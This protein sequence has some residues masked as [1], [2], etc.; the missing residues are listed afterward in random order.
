MM[1]RYQFSEVFTQAERREYN[2]HKR[3]RFSVIVQVVKIEL[4][5]REK[6]LTNMG[7]SGAMSSSV[8]LLPIP[9][10]EAYPKLPDSLLV[11]LERELTT[12][13]IS[14]RP[15][16]LVSGNRMVGHLFSSAS[17]FPMDHQFPPISPQRR[18]CQNSAFIPKSSSDGV[19][20]PLTQS[21]RSGVQSAPLINYPKEKKDDCW[22]TNSLQDIIEIPESVSIQNGQVGSST[23][24][25][26]SADHGKRTDWQEWADQLFNV[27]DALEPNWSDILVD[28]DV[29]DPEPKPQVPS[30]QAMS[31]REV[32]T[33]ADPLSAAS[34][35]KPRMR[36]T[37]E[38]HEAFVDA[39]NQ[40]G[41]SERATPKGVLKLM[42][43]ERLTIYHVKSHLQK[44]RTARYK[45]EASEERKVTPIEDVASLEVKT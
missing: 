34:L 6:K 20:L 32:V 21:C 16:P 17:G 11:T 3:S 13:P 42:N 39:V 24:V 12:N 22:S 27:D 26:T 35:T 5:C 18:H 23:G 1:A 45:P 30:H 2:C 36:W 28:V 8:P 40:L 33:G 19:S 37:P 14:S 7:I 41:G 31:S 43:V 10:E 44:Y 38:L 29:P 15:T 9:L 4:H 25:M